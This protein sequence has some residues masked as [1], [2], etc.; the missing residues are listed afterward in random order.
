MQLRVINQICIGKPVPSLLWGKRFDKHMNCVQLLGQK[1]TANVVG[2]ARY[3]LNWGI[4][5][6]FADSLDFATRL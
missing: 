6:V 1:R 2:L 4:C 3:S 5:E